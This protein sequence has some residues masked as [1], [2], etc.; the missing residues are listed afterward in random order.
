MNPLV[1]LYVSKDGVLRTNIRVTGR[2][3]LGNVPASRNVIERLVNGFQQVE[4]L[5]GV[6]IQAPSRKA[7]NASGLLSI[8]SWR[9]NQH[10]V[11]ERNGKA[12]RYR[13]TKIIHMA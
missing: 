11:C 3:H 12:C 7:V 1:A 10:S 4:Y 2:L 13:P 5:L 8:Q 6:A 9:S